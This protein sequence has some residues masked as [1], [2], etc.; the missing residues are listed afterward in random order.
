MSGAC[1]LKISVPATN[2]RPT[3]LG[4]HHPATPGLAV[5]DRDQL[6]RLP[7]IALHQLPRPIDGPLKR[8]PGHKPRPDLAHVVIEDRLAA[9][10]AH[11]GG[12][13]TQPLRLNP[14]ITLK[15]LADPVPKRIELRRSR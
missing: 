12:H 1:L 15:L 14:R 9:L 8:A 4:G 11:L 3:Q 6:A 5:T 13:L 7:Q 10:I 2:P